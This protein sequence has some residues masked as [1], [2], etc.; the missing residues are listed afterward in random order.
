[1]THNHEVEYFYGALE[2]ALTDTLSA[3]LAATSR[4]SGCHGLDIKS[5]PSGSWPARGNPDVRIT[6]RK[7][8]R[9]LTS[10]AKSI[11]SITP[12][13]RISAKIMATSRPRISIVARAASARHV[14]R[15]SR[16]GTLWNISS[17][18]LYAGC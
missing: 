11:P 12:G 4:L 1:M 2:A 8:Q 13:S 18:A 3:C 16:N 6:G 10:G 17:L 5:I 7:G 14:E 15:N 9:N